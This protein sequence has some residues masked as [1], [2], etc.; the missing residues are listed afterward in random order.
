MC[1]F[2]IGCSFSFEQAL[3]DAGIAGEILPPPKFLNFRFELT[4]FTFV[5]AFFFHSVRN[6]EQC[7]NVSMYK[8]SIG[9]SWAHLFDFIFTA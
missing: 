2:F 5:F 3:Q 7:K 8:T 1:A 4:I 6:I 9:V